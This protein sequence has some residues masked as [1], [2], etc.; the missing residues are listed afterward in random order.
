MDSA[1]EPGARRADLESVLEELARDT[2]CSGRSGL[3]LVQLM[4]WL[5]TGGVP[6][7]LAWGITGPRVPGHWLLPLRCSS[8][9]CRLR[10]A[11]FLGSCNDEIVHLY[12]REGE[13]EAG[14][15]S[16][17]LENSH[18]GPG[19]QIGTE[20]QPGFM[21]FGVHSPSTPLTPAP[22]WGHGDIPPLLQTHCAFSPTL[23]AEALQ[24]ISDR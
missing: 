18:P 23:P 24:L 6:A 21:Q 1:P 9:V 3:G 17:Q 20:G 8:L 15:E 14:A 4:L 10:D 22:W 16:S 7:A 2:L 13:E 12:F 11:D 5:K 19:A